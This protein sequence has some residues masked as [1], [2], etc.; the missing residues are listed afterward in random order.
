M[1]LPG[2]PRMNCLILLKT[3]ICQ[4][5]AYNGGGQGR[6]FLH[7]LS[8]IN[9]NTLSCG[10]SVLQSC[11]RALQAVASAK[12]CGHVEVQRRPRPQ[13]RGLNA[14]FTSPALPAI[15]FFGLCSFCVGGSEGLSPFFVRRRNHILNVS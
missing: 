2:S 3:K 15:A 11:R 5:I 13:S 4:V 6:L 14:F 9:H 12:A 8:P 1:V 7:R 10:L